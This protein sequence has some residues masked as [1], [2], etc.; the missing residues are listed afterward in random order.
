MEEVYDGGRCEQCGGMIGRK[1]D[2]T[3]AWPC[4]CSLRVVNRERVCQEELRGVSLAEQ[5]SAQYVIC[6]AAFYGGTLSDA[7]VISTPSSY[8]AAVRAIN[9]LS[10]SA[11]VYWIQLAD[12]RPNIQR[13]CWSEELS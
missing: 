5:K 12:Y 1:Y 2:D 11:F 10:H 3:K 13:A 6:Q 4:Y 9:V 8:R 7:R